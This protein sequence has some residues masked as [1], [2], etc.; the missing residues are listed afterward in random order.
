M[1]GLYFGYGLSS[2]LNAVIG[3]L[4]KGKISVLWLFLIIG[5]TDWAFISLVSASDIG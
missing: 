5:L 2:T 3:P 1:S 4:P